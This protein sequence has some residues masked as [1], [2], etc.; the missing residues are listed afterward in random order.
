MAHE[1][2]VQQMLTSEAPL[3]IPLPKLIFHVTLSVSH[4]VGKTCVDFVYRSS[5]VGH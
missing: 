3:L 5:L 1:E 2:Y 4:R